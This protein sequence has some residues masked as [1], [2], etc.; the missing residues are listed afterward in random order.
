M[1][2]G[3][4]PSDPPRADHRL[5]KYVVETFYGKK[6]V[7]SDPREFGVPRTQRLPGL[8][9]SSCVLVGS[10]MLWSGAYLTAA[11]GK[12]HVECDSHAHDAKWARY[13]G[14]S[15]EHEPHLW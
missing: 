15:V 4:M 13:L 6:G 14:R 7:Q 3:I 8:E 9:H 10:R 5:I 11:C 12:R 2:K 1:S